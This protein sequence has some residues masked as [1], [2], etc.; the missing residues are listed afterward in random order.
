MPLLKSSIRRLAPPLLLSAYHWVLSW[1]SDFYYRHPSRKMVVIGITGTSGKSSTTFILRHIL[2]TA[3]LKVGCISTMEFCNGEH[4]WLND[5]KMTM[6]GRM[7]AQTMLGDMVDHGCDVAIVETT[8]EGI[9]QHRHR[10]IAYDIVAMTNLYPEHIESH[11]SFEN[12]QK[13]KEKLFAR[14]WYTPRKNLRLFGE[15]QRIKKTIVVNQDLLQAGDFTRYPADERW[16]FGQQSD[17]KN[18]VQWQMLHENKKGTAFGLNGIGMQTPLWGEHNVAN[19]ALAATVA[20]S[21]GVD[22]SQVAT[23]AADIAALP[24]RIE[25]VDAGQPYTVIVDYAF[26]PK[27][28]AAL[29]HVVRLLEPKKIIHVFGSTG[30]GRDVQ[31]RF[32]VGEYVG[33]NADVCIITDE[34]PYD[35]DPQKIIDDVASAVEKTGKK[36]GE[37]LFR[38]LDRREAI[39][40]ALQLAQPGDIV[41]I[42]GKGSEQRMVVA[43]GEMIPWD[44]REVVR[45]E[46]GEL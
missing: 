31:R 10:H 15:P 18:H 19:I 42:T 14:L 7:Q 22:L 12:Y 4:C 45:E 20:M 21:L 9:V 40:K 36:E 35:D 28:M 41:L 34:D 5:R 29:Y 26:E 43:G 38:I 24:G 17:G 3:G 44:D 37:N 8:S 16:T 1:W 27:A 39:S 30:G 2:E 32:T 23:A 46:M 13:A 33:Q 11:G 25:L 6:L